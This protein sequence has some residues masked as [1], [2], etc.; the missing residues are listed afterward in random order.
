MR[1][2]MLTLRHGIGSQQKLRRDRGAKAKKDKEMLTFGV[3]YLALGAP[4]LAMAINSLLSL[5]ITNPGI[6]VCVITNVVRHPPKKSWWSFEIG[7]QWVFKDI[8]TKKS[9]C[10]NG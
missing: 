8:A 3:V 10:E 1:L 6:P 7:D 5:R 2:E 4:Y 9:I